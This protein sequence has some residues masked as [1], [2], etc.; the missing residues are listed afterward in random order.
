MQHG[1]L[2][3]AKHFLPLVN[4][5]PSQWAG[6]QK[7]RIAIETLEIFAPLAERLGMQEIRAELDDLSFKIIEPEIRESIV[8][9]LEMLRQQ[10]EDLLHKTINMIKDLLDKNK[11]KADIYGREK[12]PFSIWKKMKVKSVNFSQLSDIMAFTILLDSPEQCYLVLGL[13]HQKYS[14]VPGRFKDYIS[15]PKP[16]LYIQ[17]L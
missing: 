4:F 6:G 9:R 7:K 5:D 8:Y 13:L 12:K 3:K 16:N 11:I 10:D 1:N 2:A 17:H 14:Y 15:T